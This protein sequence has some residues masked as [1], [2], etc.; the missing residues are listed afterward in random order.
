MACHQRNTNTRDPQ[1]HAVEQTCRRRTRK[2]KKGLSQTLPRWEKDSA[3]HSPFLHS[4]TAGT[5]K[6]LRR[7]GFF[8][9]WLCCHFGFDLGIRVIGAERFIWIQVF[10]NSNLANFGSAG[11][12]NCTSPR[13]EIGTHR[14]TLRRGWIGFERVHHHTTME[15]KCAGLSCRKDIFVAPKTQ[16]REPQGQ[17]R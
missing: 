8:C 7:V 12:A 1:F 17:W 10:V 3:I 13:E 4:G 16:K 15:A 14:Q 11:P 6:T 5:S 9:G 2:E